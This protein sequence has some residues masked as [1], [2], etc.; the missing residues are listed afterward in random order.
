MYLFFFRYKTSDSGVAKLHSLIKVNIQYLNI[1]LSHSM[2]G[3]DVWGS[4]A[5]HNWQQSAKYP[6]RKKMPRVIWKLFDFITYWHLCHGFVWI[7]I[8]PVKESYSRRFPI[9]SHP[10]RLKLDDSLSLLTWLPTD[11]LISF[12][13]SSYNKAF[14]SQICRLLFKDTVNL[15]FLFL[16][17][18]A[19]SWKNN[20]LKLL[21]LNWCSILFIS[22]NFFTFTISNKIVCSYKLEIH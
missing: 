17:A 14:E 13:G 8:D 22:M 19:N 11:I 7:P 9:L 15:H 5:P 18:I 1:K 3:S 12:F 10:I 4:S 2:N 20:H 16:L 6:R 21:N